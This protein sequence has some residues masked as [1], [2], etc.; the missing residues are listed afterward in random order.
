MPRANIAWTLVAKDLSIYDSNM[1][2]ES[3]KDYVVNKSDLTSCSLCSEPAPHN[4]RTKLLLCK[5]KAC[6]TVAP[7]ARCLWKGRVQ[8]CI[9][10][11]VVNLWEANQHVSPLRSPREAR[12][13][14]EMKAFARDMCTYNHKPMNIY[15]GI[16]KRFQVAE[17]AMPKLT[18]VQRFVQHYRRAH[19]GGSDY[20]DDVVAK[21]REHAYRGEEEPGVPFTFMWRSNANGEAIVGRGSDADTFAVGM[22]SKLLRRLDRDL[23]TYVLHLDATYKLSQVEYPVIVVSISDCMSSFHLVAFFI[24]SLQTEH[25]FAEALSMLR[26]MYTLATNKQLSVRFIMA[27]ADKAQRNAVDSVLGVNN[28]LVNLM[29]GFHV[30]AKVYKRTRGIPI[31]LAAQVARDI[32]D[33]HY[34][35]S[36]AELELTKAR[37]MESWDKLPQLSAFAT[38]FRSVRLNSKFHRWQAFHTPRGFAA[39]NNHIEQFNH[40]IKRDYTLR[41]RLKMGTLIDQLLLCVKTEGVR[42]RPVATEIQPRPDMVRRVREM[43]KSKTI[44]ETTPIKHSIGFL[45]GDEQLPATSITVHV[46]SDTL[47]RVY[48]PQDRLMNEEL[49]VAACLSVQNARMETTGIPATGW[50]VDVVA[51]TA[52]PCVPESWMLCPSHIRAV[53]A[54][55]A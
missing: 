51:Q 22:S 23:A 9:L 25:H 39:T 16:V 3:F 6:K 42:G 31:A 37:C 33:M 54:G 24:L 11:N 20:H 43:T 44:R 41:A 32:A 2:L 26:R 14:E 55:S 50:Q 45:T 35:T 1:L 29:C 48:D 7:Y 53:R 47:E 18:T 38:Y 12:L 52:V 13:I 27:D 8:I 40:A 28:E 10:S 34:A 36:E 5:C 30:A 21:V 19:L 46:V 15:N 17:G 4:M 49:P